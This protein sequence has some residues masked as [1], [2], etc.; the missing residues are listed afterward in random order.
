MD[1]NKYLNGVKINI[2]Y[3]A[4]EKDGI[5]YVTDIQIKK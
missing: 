4:L 1:Y 3:R 2:T 5:T